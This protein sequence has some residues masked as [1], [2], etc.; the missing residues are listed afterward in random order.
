MYYTKHTSQK[1][2]NIIKMFSRSEYFDNAIFNTLNV[3]NIRT[4]VYLNGINYSSLYFLYTILHK[5]RDI[6]TNLQKIN[7]LCSLLVG[8]I[9]F[10]T[11]SYLFF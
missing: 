1:V 10:K 5:N 2:L 9:I 11:V 4:I 7:Y 3:H 6:L 8:L